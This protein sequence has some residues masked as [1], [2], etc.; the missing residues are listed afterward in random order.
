MEHYLFRLVN[1][2]IKGEIILDLISSTATTYSQHGKKIL[3]FS[4]TF[5]KQPQQRQHFHSL[6]MAIEEISLR[7]IHS[8]SKHLPTMHLPRAQTQEDSGEM[9]HPMTD[10]SDSPEAS[11]LE[12][13]IPS[14]SVVTPDRAP[15]ELSVQLSNAR[16]RESQ[17]DATE[18]P[19]LQERLRSVISAE[20]DLE[21]QLKSQEVSAIDAEIAKIHSMML[22][23]KQAYE[24]NPETVAAANSMPEF[25]DF[26]ANFFYTKTQPKK[27]TVNNSH[28][29]N[30]DSSQDLDRDGS[31]RKRH[32]SFNHSNTTTPAKML[33]SQ[34]FSTSLSE[35]P[36]RLRKQDSIDRPSVTKP[37]CIIRRNDG[38]L[39][40]LVCPKCHRDNFGSAQGFI[41][42]CRISH[43]LEL[44]THD[45]AAVE[46]GVEVEEQ[47]E[48]GLDAKQRMA[49]GRPSRK[50]EEAS[51]A[52][53]LKKTKA[54]R[55]KRGFVSNADSGK[56]ATVES[57]TAPVDKNGGQLGG[58]YR[59]GFA[60]SHWSMLPNTEG[61]S[62]FGGKTL[63][64]QVTTQHVPGVRRLTTGSSTKLGRILKPTE[65]ARSMSSSLG[66]IVP[67]M[68]LDSDEEEEAEEDELDSDNH[69]EEVDEEDEVSGDDE[70]D[71][72]LTKG[73][74]QRR[75]SSA[76]TLPG[77]RPLPS[78][79]KP[80]V[81]G[82]QKFMPLSRFF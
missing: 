56:K 49:E 24:T 43:S 63:P 81:D 22:Q 2:H 46:C 17:L 52:N 58:K 57:T 7:S 33:R 48:I 31:M 14:S 19:T 20:F 32:Y 9:D 79:S 64:G 44:T 80:P 4:K 59:P 54:N 29:R 77:S 78:A 10:V 71:E 69:K 76:K 1:P 36:S 47:D 45:A 62:S 23:I 6:S 35:R 27:A 39:V 30:S 28:A 13:V 34:S 25:T 50:V 60:P 65:K 11:S 41:N 26:Y 37:K 40:R 53:L 42:H 18:Q 51:A 61:G 12:I 67:T 15:L 82:L 74:A 55:I 16:D 8:G 73:F 38:V 3:H 21:I 5:V 72:S 66:R 70:F 75:R 68:L